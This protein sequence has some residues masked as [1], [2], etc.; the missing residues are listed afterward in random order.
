[1]VNPPFRVPIAA[2]SNG[3]ERYRVRVN[4]A[5]FGASSRAIGGTPGS[6]TARWE[7][8]RKGLRSKGKGDG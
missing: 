5:R 6:T 2:M 3:Y 4:F 8:G 7:P 1:M